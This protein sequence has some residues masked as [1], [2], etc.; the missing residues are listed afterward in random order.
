MKKE[1]LKILF[2]SGVLLFSQTASFESNIL[3]KFKKYENYKNEAKIIHSIPK[4]FVFGYKKVF[5]NFKYYQFQDNKRGD[6]LEIYRP[7]KYQYP[8]IY[9]FD[10]NNNKKFEKDELIKDMEKDGLNGNEESLN[11]WEYNLK[12]Y[13]R[14]Y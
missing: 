5:L 4:L 10:L 6:V 12:K 9:G 2:C 14:D 3:L 7:F 11:K 8:I 13:I 1:L